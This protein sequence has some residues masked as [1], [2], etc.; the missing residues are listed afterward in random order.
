MSDK[1]KNGTANNQVLDKKKRGWSRLKKALLISA[2][3]ILV[4]ATAVV[5]YG[6]AFI[7]EVKEPQRVLLDDAEFAEEYDVNELFPN[8]IVNIALIGFDRGWN[9]ENMGE[10]L[11]RPD[12]LAVFSINFDE[13]SISVVRIPRDSY[14]PIYNRGG[15]YEK[16]NHSFY[17]G[18]RSG[19]SEDPD[20]DGIRYTLQTVSN[21]LGDIPIHYYA[22]V[23]MYSIVAL[24]DAVGGIYYEVE[25]PIYDKYWNVG[26]LLVPEGPQIMDGKTYLR[27]LQYRD[28]STGGDIGRIDR[29]MNLLKETIIYLKEEGK[30]TDVPTIYRIYKD[31][32]ETDLSYKQIA[33]LAYYARDLEIGDDNFDFYTI[34]GDGAMKDGRWLQIIRQNERVQ[35]IK[36][37][38]GIDVETWP[39]IE[40]KDSPEYLA[41]QE[42]RRREEELGELYHPFDNEE[43]DVEEEVTLE[44]DEAALIRIP[45]IRGL[46]VGE[47]R[48]LLEDVGLDPGEIEESYYEVLEK[49]LVI[50]SDPPSGKNVPTG[51]VINLVV[52]KGPESHDS[53]DG[54]ED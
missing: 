27:Y 45:E 3:V 19:E 36:E 52:S 41:E 12:M 49:G 15:A 26:E 33:A 48:S 38:F 17:F 21:V 29:Q 11:F 24:V 54:G 32:V 7:E 44:E 47:A 25:E 8:H 1:K 28:G 22:S 16:I 31:Y 14:V 39:P 5:G 10:Y 37:V 35:I 4:A 30:L 42:K 46:T 6:L 23:D 53:S 51:T 13:D 34:P 18:Y 50:Y 20:A 43:Q 40:I 9:R 2:A